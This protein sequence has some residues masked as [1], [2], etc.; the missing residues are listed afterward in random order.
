[1]DDGDTITVVG[2]GS[3]DVE[4]DRVRVRLGVS[5]VAP[6]IGE[7][8]TEAADAQRRMID[9]LAAEGLPRTAIQTAGYHGGRD[10][11]GR[12]GSNRQ[13]VDVTLT[14]VLPDVT[15]AGALLGRLGDAA[16][17]AFRVD[18]ISLEVADPEPHRRAARA[19][20]V[21]A[22]REQAEELATAAGVRLGR[23]Q[24]LFEGIALPGPR[25]AAGAQ[26]MARAAPGLEGGELGVTV[27]VTASYEIVQ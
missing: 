18:G 4:P 27:M 16:G 25:P 21:V 19:A 10:H 9:V 12:D 5:T 17:T 22:A 6:T 24:S 2:V 7:A 13:R 8:M 14:V 1:M 23:L 26:L 11:E 3:V 15:G 20:A